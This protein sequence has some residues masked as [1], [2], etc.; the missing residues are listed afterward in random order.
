MVGCLDWRSP[1]VVRAL[2]IREHQ[3]AS[4]VRQRLNPVVG[5]LVVVDTISPVSCSNRAGAECIVHSDGNTP[6]ASQAWKTRLASHFDVSDEEVQLTLPSCNV[7]PGDDVWIGKQ[8][9]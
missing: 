7:Q 2:S 6:E 4:E 9:M 3:L 5:L 1:G 8:M